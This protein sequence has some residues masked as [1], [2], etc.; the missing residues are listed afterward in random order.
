MGVHAAVFGLP[1]VE[2]CLGDPEP[3]G[4]I[5]RLR[6]CLVLAQNRDD[7]LFLEP[8]SLRGLQSQLEEIARGRSHPAIDSIC[9]EG[10]TMAGRLGYRLERTGL[11][12]GHR[13]AIGELI[14]TLKRLS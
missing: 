13:F 6:P 9:A 10:S 11:N 1:V 5:G 7:L 12:Y 2:C 3:V 4:Q 14:A 8:A